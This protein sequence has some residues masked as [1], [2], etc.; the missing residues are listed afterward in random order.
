MC[1]YV[2]KTELNVMFSCNLNHIIEAFTV[3][4]L[5][6]TFQRKSTFFFL[7]V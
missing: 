5:K 4:Q 2:I 7:L 1:G 6:V 3:T